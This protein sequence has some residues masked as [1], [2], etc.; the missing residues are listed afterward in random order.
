MDEGQLHRVQKCACSRTGR[1]VRIG[2]GAPR[3]TGATFG[4]SLLAEKQA[5]QR[6][7]LARAAEARAQAQMGGYVQGAAQAPRRA[8]GKLKLK[9]PNAKQLKKAAQAAKMVGDAGAQMYGYDSLV[10]AGVSN[11]QAAAAERGYDNQA[12]RAVSKYAKKKGDKL[13]DQQLGGKIQW[14]KVGKTALKV[15]KVANKISKQATGQS[16]TDLG[17][18]MAMEPLSRVDPTGGIASDLLEKQ[19]Q[20]QANKQLDKR[21]G[22]F[23]KQGSNVGVSNPGKAGPIVRSK[24]ADDVQ[25]P[26]RWVS[27]RRM[28]L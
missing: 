7:Q 13:V 12:T 21:G 17:I 14:K 18:S 26:N 28:Q 20:N 10:D 23:Y 24:Y 3:T 15:G 19:L 9:M 11:A 8:G 16:L 27:V 25:N 4:A 2:G 22:S 6:A 1:G 5:R